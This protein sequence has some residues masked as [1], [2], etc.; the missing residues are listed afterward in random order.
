MRV[1]YCPSVAD[2]NSLVSLGTEAG[3]AAT[4]PPEL[5]ERFTSFMAAS[6]RPVEETIE[7]FEEISE[8]WGNRYERVRLTLAPSNV[9]RC[10]D[11]L[12]V[13]FRELANK[14]KTGIHI[15]LQ[16]SIY[17]KLEGLR[18]WNKTPLQHLNDLGF[19]GPD[20]VCGHSVWVTDEDIEVMAATGTNVCHNASSNLRI[21][22]GIAPIGKLL[23]EGHPGS[24]R[25]RRGRHQR[26]QGPAPGDAPSAEDPQGPRGGDRSPHILRGVPDGH[27]ERRLR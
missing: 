8:R 17:Q 7:S 9:H 16:E 2:Q 14:H 10:S 18:A 15:H 21:S 24:H 19:L 27:G 12:L 4:L 5:A 22:S 20:V 11:E 26:R 23:R 1:S 3:F 13:A 6:Y 25:Q